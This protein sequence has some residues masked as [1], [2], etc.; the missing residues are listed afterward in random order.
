M[1]SQVHTYF[2]IKGYKLDE[3]GKII[4]EYF[5]NDDMNL[6]SNSLGLDKI[7]NSTDFQSTFDNKRRIVMLSD[8][9][10]KHAYEYYD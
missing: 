2:F 4:N 9:G 3:N 8:T 5:T 10:I 1:K 7:I 6:T